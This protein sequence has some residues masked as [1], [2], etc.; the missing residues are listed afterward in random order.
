M[1]KS[2]ATIFSLLFLSALPA[3]SQCPTADIL[4]NTQE[5]IDDFSADYPGC[6]DLPF[7]I[8]IDDS[9]SNTITNLD[10]LLQI[11]SVDRFILIANNGALTNFNG[12]NNLT[13]VGDF[14]AI[15]TNQSLNDLSALANLNS[16]GGYL[17]VGNNDG[18]SSLTGLQNITA[19][20]GYLSIGNN[21]LLADLT[22]LAGISTV[23][24]NVSIEFNPL[25]V[26]LNGL[27]NLVSV[28]G[29]ISV[30]WNQ[31]LV[32]LNGIQN[33]ITMGGNL[34]ISLN[35]NLSSLSGLDNLDEQGISW[36]Y[37][38]SNPQLSDCATPPICTYLSD[39]GNGTS[40]SSNG[41]GCDDRLEVEASCS[42]LPVR[43]LSFAG[44][45]QE[46]RHLLKWQTASE[47]D[48]AG[49]FV[50]RSTSVGYWEEIGFVEG[51]GDQTQTSSYDFIDYYPSTGMNYYR[52]KQTDCDGAI[53]YSQVVSLEG[54]ASAPMLFPNP[55]ADRIK[56]SGIDSERIEIIDIHGIIHLQNTTSSWG[57]IDVS[58]LPAGTYQIRATDST[59]VDHRLTFVKL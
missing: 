58:S 51:R 47:S 54:Q 18:L 39:A 53:S 19:V 56:I 45:S 5:E 17:V 11:T 26:D 38:Q 12:L 32:N 16:V 44:E 29:G 49:F 21:D 25:L 55:T 6:T 52:L 50:E 46:G 36:L 40:I 2:I 9:L 48:N 13:T 35:S 43:L 24:N 37:V 10:G 1:I 33:L 23:A 8:T 34:T 42:L 14:L 30:R 57:E 15:Q 4:L 22:G 7:G 28:G 20:G 41:V 59:G 27:Q 31:T 3:T